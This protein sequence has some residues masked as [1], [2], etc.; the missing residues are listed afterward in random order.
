MPAA[1]TPLESL[2]LPTRCVLRFGR[3]DSQ[4]SDSNSYTVAPRSDKS[5][6]NTSSNKP[7]HATYGGGSIRSTFNPRTY[8]S[9]RSASEVFTNNVFTDHEHNGHGNYDP[10]PFLADQEP[11]T[12]ED[13]NN[14]S[15]DDGY[16]RGA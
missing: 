11:D 14:Y 16:T 2:L 8:A 13:N 15:D 7:A 5:N 10:E 6:N 3:P 4:G 12:Y 1:D 9:N